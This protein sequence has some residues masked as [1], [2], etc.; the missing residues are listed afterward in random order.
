MRKLAEDRNDPSVH[1]RS[2]RNDGSR[3]NADLSRPPCQEK[4][5]AIAAP[6]SSAIA[7]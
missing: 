1:R 6:H 5:C 3:P 2:A 4:V 7:G